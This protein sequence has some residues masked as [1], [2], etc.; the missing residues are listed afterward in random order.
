MFTVSVMARCP[1]QPIPIHLTPHRS[2]SCKRA[3]SI[4]YEHKNILRAL[5]YNSSNP[6][7]YQQSDD[8]SVTQAIQ[9]DKKS[10]L[11]TYRDDVAIY[12]NTS[13]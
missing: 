8:G 9:I 5:S 2:S 10:L 12:Y 6:G 13:N 11:Y 3:L 7:E 4:F 1:A